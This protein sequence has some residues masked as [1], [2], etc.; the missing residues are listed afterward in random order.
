MITH[1]N[2]NGSNLA[3]FGYTNNNLLQMSQP[4]AFRYPH[5]YCRLSGNHI[6]HQPQKR[7]LDAG[8]PVFPFPAQKHLFRRQV[9]RLRKGQL[10]FISELQMMRVGWEGRATVLGERQRWPLA[11][12]TNH[13]ATESLFNLCDSCRC[14]WSFFVLFYS[15]SLIQQAF[16]KAIHHDILLSR[17]PQALRS[18]LLATNL[19]TL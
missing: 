6:L 5:L 4:Q 1:R 7:L 18:F 19:L 10:V 17:G 8:V 15:F 2:E 13:T 16:I 9:A 14:Q 3:P 11:F 12:C